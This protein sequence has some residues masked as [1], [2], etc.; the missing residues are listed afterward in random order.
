MNCKKCGKEI[1]DS[2]DD[3]CDECKQKI[4]EQLKETENEEVETI[5]EDENNKTKKFKNV[6]NQLKETILKVCNR[7]KEKSINSSLYKKIN[8]L[9]KKAKLVILTII[10]LFIVFLILIFSPKYNKIGNTMGNIRNYG[11]VASEG[12]W[13]YY[14]SPNEDK[15]QICINRTSKNGKQKE[16]I[17]ET[18][19]DVVSINAYKGYLY[20]IGIIESDAETIELEDDDVD[21]KI[22]RIKADGSSDIEIINNNEFNNECFEIYVLDNHVYYIGTDRNIYKMKLDGTDKEL[23]SDNGTGYIGITDK[24]ILYNDVAEED[25]DEENSEESEESNTPIFETKIMSIDGKD[26]RTLVKGLRL[27]SVNLKDNYV[28]YTKEENDEENNKIIPIYRTKIDSNEEEL[29][30][31][32][33]AY[34][35]NLYENNLYYFNYNNSNES[36]AKVCIYKVNANGKKSEPTQLKILDTYSTFLNIANDR[37]IYMDLNSRYSYIKSVNLDGNKEIKLYEVDNG[38]AE[39][40][41]DFQE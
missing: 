7:I 9:N 16:K 3:I 10:V 19:M 14:L 5:K 4:I 24:Y 13:T 25:T 34:N 22:Y 17:Y 38:E 1:I 36:K 15:T 21:N 35:L 29:I 30:T 2:E 26:K 18:N 41:V 31:K 37:I 8:G 11:Y 23:V 12:K 20:F 33:T 27:Y 6:I 40:V 32:T 39:E 28:Y